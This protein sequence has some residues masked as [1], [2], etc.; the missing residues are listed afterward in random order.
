[1][2]EQRVALRQR[3]DLSEIIQAAITLYTQNFRP[4]FLIATLAIP[5]GIA[6]AVAVDSATDPDATTALLALFLFAQLVVDIIVIAALIVALQRIDAGQPSEFGQAYD[7]AFARLTPLFGSAIRVVFHV[8]LLAITIIGIPW[9]IQR[10]VRW[11]FVEQA[12][13]LD[14]ARARESLARSAL[15]VEGSWWRTLA[16]VLVVSVIAAFPGF[17]LSGMFL[18]A[19]V[20]VSG[21]VGSVAAAAMLPFRTIALTMLY[22]T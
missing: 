1:M 20:L 12:V 8:M 6:S 5:L 15:A 14:G 11:L 19:P 7:D 21:T 2:N 4:L 22:W 13:I 16:V 17:A 18:F 3:R 9:A 10:T